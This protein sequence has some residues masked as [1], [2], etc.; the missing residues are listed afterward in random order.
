M[1]D[2]TSFPVQFA[3]SK[4]VER[5]SLATS[6]CSCQIVVVKRSYINIKAILGL[7]RGVVKTSLRILDKV[8]SRGLLLSQFCPCLSWRSIFSCG[9]VLWDSIEKGKP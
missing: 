1:P 9:L 4:H 2:R 6:C 7:P 8:T 5:T 3:L